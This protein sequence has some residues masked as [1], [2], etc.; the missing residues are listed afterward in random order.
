MSW[1]GEMKR[2]IELARSGVVNLI[3]STKLFISQS[4]ANRA[5]WQVL[6]FFIF[7]AGMVMLESLY[8]LTTQTR[9]LILVSADNIFCCIGLGLGL[10]TIRRTTGRNGSGEQ[11]RRMES[12]AGFAN[13]ILLIYVGVLV[14]IEAIERQLE[15]GKVEYAH[16]FTVC[17][18]GSLGN[19]AGLLFFPPESRR[20]NHNVQGIYLHIWGNTLAFVGV[21]ICTILGER[22]PESLWIGVGGAILVASVIIISAIPLIITS[23]KVLTDQTTKTLPEIT[24]SLKSVSGIRDVEPV[25]LWNIA[26]GS[27]FIAVRIFAI[28]G[29]NEQQYIRI[30][31]DQ[32]VSAGYKRAK[33]FV[34]IIPIEFHRRSRS[35]TRIN[36][37]NAHIRANSC[38]RVDIMALEDA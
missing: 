33:I 10:Y 11:T 4:Q 19:I 22:S 17:V 38:S 6:N 29:N 14:V 5:S 15:E 16:T 7:Q 9:G 32:I 24:N 30:V 25:K 35:S 20:E 13:G 21:A 27:T 26:G 28:V 23:G 8:A 12:L 31:R 37:G 18:V 34:E 3:R 2:T 1:M 36:V